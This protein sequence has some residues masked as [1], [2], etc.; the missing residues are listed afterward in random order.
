MVA[1]VA[2]AAGMLMSRAVFQ[3]VA[4][5]ALAAGT[6]L[7]PPRSLPEGRF[8]DQNGAAFSAGRL[9]GHWSLLF[10][11]F[12]SCPDI[13]PTTL[14]MLAQ[15]RKALADLPEGQRPQVILVSVDPRRDT[16]E[17]LAAYV[18]YFDPS[19]LGI[20][21]GDQRALEE[22]ARQM[23]VVVSVSA[24]A[25]GSYTVDHSASVFLVDPQ[26]AL[27]ALFSPPHSAQLIARDYRA[28]LGADS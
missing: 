11:G 21:A 22:F 2:V 8:T 26:G 6:L 3:R 13:C 12:T 27:R 17:R 9:R 14:A 24:S 28:I 15:V 1:I 7:S 20:T 4:P 18:R 19:F 5:S 16:P 23:G 10:F 25:D